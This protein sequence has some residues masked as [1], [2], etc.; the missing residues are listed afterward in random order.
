MRLQRRPFWWLFGS[1]RCSH[2]HWSSFITTTCAPYSATPYPSATHTYIHTPAWTNQTFQ[3]QLI[4]SYLHNGAF[5]SHCLTLPSAYTAMARRAYCRTLTL[6]VF[7]FHPPT[8]DLRNTK[9]DC[10]KGLSTVL[11]TLNKC[12]KCCISLEWYNTLLIHT[13]KQADILIHKHRQ[14]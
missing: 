8:S 7:N 2:T 3:G 14:S 1:L 5:V 12:S 13:N 4:H 10:L 11:T 9:A 6:N